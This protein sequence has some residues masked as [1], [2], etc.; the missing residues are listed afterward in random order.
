MGSENTSRRGNTSPRIES[1]EHCD[2]RGE[3]EAMKGLRMRVMMLD[4]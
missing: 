3:D 1:G 4:I 2:H